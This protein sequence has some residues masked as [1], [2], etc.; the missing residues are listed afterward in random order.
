MEIIPD[1]TTGHGM[2]S[3]SAEISL[4]QAGPLFVFRL[5]LATNYLEK[6]KGQKD[7]RWQI[8]GLQSN[9]WQR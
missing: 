6:E 5:D 1:E 8:G 9:I 4:P 7:V 3:T 2:L